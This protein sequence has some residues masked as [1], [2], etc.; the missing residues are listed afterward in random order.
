[1]LGK[2][3]FFLFVHL[4]TTVKLKI[5]E[6]ATLIRNNYDMKNDSDDLGWS[7]R[8]TNLGKLRLVD[9]KN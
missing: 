4:L 7:T 2:C 3:E 6:V 9:K 1:M 8:I 5:I